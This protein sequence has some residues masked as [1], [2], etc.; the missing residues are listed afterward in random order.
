MQCSAS[1]PEIKNTWKDQSNMPDI[2]SK[3]SLGKLAEAYFDSVRNSTEIMQ[4][5]DKL[6]IF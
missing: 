5:E 3:T 6:N 4:I 2:S 1:A